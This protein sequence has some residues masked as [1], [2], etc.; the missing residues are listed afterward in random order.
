MIYV[1]WIIYLGGL[2]YLVSS[3]RWIYACVW[4]ILVPAV[5]WLYIRKFPSLSTV[6]GYGRIVDEPA[7]RIDRNPAGKVTFYTAL[8]CPFCPLMEQRLA[9]LGV[10]FDK[11]DVT[12]RPD[13]LSAKG[14]RTVP[15]VEVGG[16]FLTGLVSTKDLLDAIGQPTAS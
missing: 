8:G 3:S 1:S 12:L 15:V 10:Q 13:L 14:I 4:L 9:S 5:Q 16:R 11:I 2:I 7:A 6:L